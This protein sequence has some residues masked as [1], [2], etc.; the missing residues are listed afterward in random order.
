MKPGFK[1]LLVE[2]ILS[3]R[4]AVTSLLFA[5]N[6][7]DEAES[8]GAAK[9]LLQQKTFDVVLLDKSLPDGD[10]ISLISPIK[11]ANPNCVV[12]MLTSDADVESIRGAIVRGADDYVIKSAT[13]VPDLLVR[14]PIAI[15]KAAATRQLKNLEEQVKSAF[16]YEIVGPSPQNETLR[17][18]IL[19]LKGSAAPVLI[20]GESGTGKELVARR[21]NAIEEDSRRP[22]VAV[23]CGAIPENL[24]E[25]E[26]FGHKKGAFTGAI[27]DQIGK[28]ELAN[29]GDLFLDEIG[30]MPMSA[31]VRLLRV[32]QENEFIRVGDTRTIKTNCRIIA[33]TNKKLEELI[34]KGR[35]RE[36]LFYRLNVIQIAT[37]P[38]RDRMVDVPDLA[39]FF[40]LQIG[41]ANCK[42]TNSAISALMNYN[43]PGN[44]RELRNTIERA[45]ISAKRRN[46]NELIFEDINFGAPVTDVRYR[47]RKIEA[48]L[49]SELSDLSA[50][51]Y[52]EFL[53]TAHR[54]Y[55]RAA[56]E[57]T[58]GSA[59]KAAERL[60]LSRTT[61]FRRM[62][63][64]GL[65]VRNGRIYDSSKP[66]ES[67]DVDS[68]SATT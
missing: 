62:T 60:G 24:I 30:E 1:I 15:S 12:I 32:L 44:I 19:S 2:D 43:W 49:P 57:A 20:S 56:L 66:D 58:N 40:T 3:F 17:E 61:L 64:L 52:A 16:K 38:L 39:K 31:Q 42:I 65:Q 47:L 63:E 34:K 50:D 4:R 36:D 54:E 51:Q 37:T 11:D 29:G 48:S 26:L 6:Q 68:R 14:I 27:A 7:I 45:V 23:N 10:G 41:G 25:S 35:F 55:L 33:A 21:L 5:N 46:S 67:N 59:P 28:F 18:T 8:L 22:Y 9:Q 13:V 53:E